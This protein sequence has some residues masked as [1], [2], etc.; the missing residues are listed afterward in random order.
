MLIFLL[1]NRLPAL[2]TLP[3]S[4]IPP[5]PRLDKVFRAIR[6]FGIGHP[7]AVLFVSGSPEILADHV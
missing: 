6:T 3:N 5:N 1:G 7:L 2:Y 4:N